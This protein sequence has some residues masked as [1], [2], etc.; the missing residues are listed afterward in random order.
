[1]TVIIRY[2][3]Y[4]SGRRIRVETA[5]RHGEYPDTPE[6]R[7]QARNCAS[8]F[9]HGRDLVVDLRGHG[10]VRR[11]EVVDVMA[12]KLGRPVAPY[13][14]EHCRRPFSCASAR[15]RHRANGICRVPE[16]CGMTW[17]SDRRGAAAFGW[18]RMET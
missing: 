10:W 4:G 13:A 2:R 3:R 11:D 5:E 14:C 17:L 7:R 8:L 6:G 12:R 9:A 16:E 18:P 1:M 15:D